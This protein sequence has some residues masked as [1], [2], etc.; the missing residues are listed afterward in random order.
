[1]TNAGIVESIDNVLA[2][3]FYWFSF[4][5]LHLQAS[6]KRINHRREPSSIIELHDISCFNTIHVVYMTV[7]DEVGVRI[8]RLCCMFHR[9]CQR[10]ILSPTVQHSEWYCVLFEFMDCVR[11][12]HDVRTWE[13]Q[14]RTVRTPSLITLRCLPWLS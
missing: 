14:Y 9:C 2:S 7:T 12:E 13:I 11:F 4:F 3:I 8:V 6:C 10:V 1:M 5:T